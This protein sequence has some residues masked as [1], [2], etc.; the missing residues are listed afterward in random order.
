MPWV[1]I[2]AQDVCF[3]ATRE[4]RACARCRY[5]TFTFLTL[6]HAPLQLPVTAR[7]FT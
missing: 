7:T 1:S 2:R 5:F 6:L 3:A 4:G